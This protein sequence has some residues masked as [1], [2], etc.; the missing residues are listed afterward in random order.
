MRRLAAAALLGAAGAQTTDEA[1][2]RSCSATYRRNA[3]VADV[4][5]VIQM[6]KHERAADCCALCLAD[7][8]CEA[9]TYADHKCALAST[10][11][12]TECAD[13]RT[14]L[15]RAPPEGLCRLGGGWDRLCRDVPKRL[16][17]ALMSVADARLKFPLVYVAWAA[18]LA[19]AVG[20]ITSRNPPPRR[21]HRNAINVHPWLRRL[22]QHWSSPA[23]ALSRPALALKL[24]TLFTLIFEA[25]A[26]SAPEIAVLGAPEVVEL[27]DWRYPKPGKDV[28]R[29]TE[30]LLPPGV[31]GSMDVATAT[32]RLVLLRRL[33]VCGW[34]A[35]LAIPPGKVAAFCFAAGSIG[36]FG[37]GS[38]ALM[39]N[40]C[41]NIQAS[42]L[43]VLI[44]SLAAPDLHENERSGRWLRHCTVICILSPLYLMS[45]VSKI[46]YIGITGNF[47]GA[48]L[49]AKP[50]F[51]RNHAPLRLPVIPM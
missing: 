7:D 15:R 48:W 23:Y 16:A 20:W 30:F 4:V 19:F 3:C 50:G 37:L 45:G 2:A 25:L 35:F 47:S 8:R 18:L 39:Y 44:A 36:Y 42:L 14:A 17:F 40:H 43:F 10:D 32:R 31:D 12:T 26:L 34:L 46:R 28:P 24:W 33:L 21:H 27:F 41:H 13:G 11:T 49:R 29:L 51:A 22:A 9:V 5:E 38:V 6:E 1:A